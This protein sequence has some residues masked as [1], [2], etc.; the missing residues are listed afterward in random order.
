MN[1]MPDAVAPSVEPS[2]LSR[3]DRRAGVIGILGTPVSSGN[4]GVQALGAALISLCAEAS[5]SMEVVLL[6][7]NRNSDSA[8][9]RVGGV[10]QQI[11]VVHARNS[12]RTHPRHH[13]LWILVAALIYRALP[14]GRLRAAVADST[15]WIKAVADAKF[16]G[17]VRGGDSFSDIYGFRRFLMGFLKAWT[18][19]L[20]KGS[21]V[22]FP[23]TYG[24]YKNSLARWLAA[25]LL[26]RSSVIIARDKKSQ[27]LAQKLAGPDK[28]V[29]LSPDVA[30]SLFAV[31]ADSVV[32]SPPILKSTCPKIIGLNVNGLVYS[33]GY[34]RND[35]F[36]LKLNY[37]AFLQ[38]LAE[39]LLTRSPGE[40]WL[41]PHTFAA[42]GD[43]EDDLEA[44]RL[45]REA[46]PQELRRRVRIVS[47]DYDANEIKGIIGTCDFFIGSRMHACIGA[48]S[49]G[50]PC[51]GVAYSQKFRGVFESVGMADWVIDGRE[52]RDEDAVMRILD[53]YSQRD[54][55]RA[56]LAANADR[57]RAELR[58][59]FSRLMDGSL[60]AEG[61]RPRASQRSVESCG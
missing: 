12:P 10:R 36:G 6:Q 44:S 9:F 48:L 46:L 51:I 35:M 5:D 24:P 30:F 33:G 22:Q 13:L 19:I 8:A 18:V 40:L 34:T 3:R 43:V 61:E 41:V 16:V 37:A 57:A 28:T 17:D 42:P 32:T 4:R 54:A 25:F 20:V 60:H 58:R 59:L 26:K 39:A 49:Q 55:V 23:Q 52:Y 14:R 45:L 53:L 1:K 11:A 27:E 29:F 50:I 38:K 15:P 21:I 47:R 2:G 56:P 31:R 7:E